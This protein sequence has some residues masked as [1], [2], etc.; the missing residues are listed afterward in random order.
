MRIAINGW[1][2][3]QSHTGSGQYTQQLLAHML[4]IAPDHEYIL[5]TPE[6]SQP[7]TS[8]EDTV[9]HKP[10]ARKPG[11]GKI[12]FEQVTFSRAC[13]R[14]GAELAHVPYWGS[15]LSPTVPT[16]VTIHD[17]IPLLLPEYRGNALVRT[18]TGLVQSAAREAALI[19]TDSMASQ[20]DIVTH[21]G[22]PDAKVRVVYLAADAALSPQPASPAPGTG[23]DDDDTIRNLYH[24]PDEYVLYLGS[25]DVR[26]NLIGLLQAWTFAEEPLGESTPLVIAGRLPQHA[27]FSPDPR[28]IARALGINPK[29]LL[30]PGPIEEAHKAAVYRGALC[31]LFPS[32]YEGFGLPA[33]E[34]LSCGVPV[35]GSNTSSIPE[36]VGDAGVLVSPDD[37]RQIAGALIAIATEPETR[38]QLAQRASAQAARFSWEKTAQQTLAAY[39]EVSW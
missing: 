22:I 29:T 12:W 3:G 11:P 10:V 16:L 30:F 39:R 9:P 23:G 31:F 35:V 28:E 36:I 33:L 7:I 25:F 19:L 2:W 8:H 21:M 15:P 38:D 34:A 6:G 5:V 4:Q 14:L 32:R 24:L 27:A 1:F 20:Q 13:R 37:T 17:I 18:Y 26:K